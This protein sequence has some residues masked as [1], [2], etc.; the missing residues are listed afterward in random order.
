MS[1]AL[2]Y[3]LLLKNFENL[4]YG[5]F[6]YVISKKTIVIHLGHNSKAFGLFLFGI[7]KRQRESG[8]AQLILSNV[9]RH[10]PKLF[11][12]FQ[13]ADTRRV[14]CARRSFREYKRTVLDRDSVTRL[15]AIERSYIVRSRT[16]DSCSEDTFR[17][18][19]HARR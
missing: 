6:K 5:S 16:R 8:K 17:L 13:P 2:N 19:I 7:E 4:Y 12:A 3:I 11:S 10:D 15:F 18:A 14:R 1:H 9:C